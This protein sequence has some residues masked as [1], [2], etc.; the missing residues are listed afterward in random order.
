METITDRQNWHLGGALRAT[1]GRFTSS[2]TEVD[3]PTGLNN[4]LWASLQ[5]VDT[6]DN[7]VQLARN[8]A[9]STDNAGDSPGVAHFEGVTA[10]QIYEF[11]AEGL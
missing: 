6:S 4:V 5:G 9:T 10:S 7:Q 11:T 8:S 1:S 2:G 3:V